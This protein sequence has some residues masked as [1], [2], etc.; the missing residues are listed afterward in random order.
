MV[1]ESEYCENG[2]IYSSK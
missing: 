2:K 1:L